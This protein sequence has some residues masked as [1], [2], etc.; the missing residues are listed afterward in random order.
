MPLVSVLII[1]DHPV[2][3]NNLFCSNNT[4]YDVNHDDSADS[5]ALEGQEYYIDV[6]P[7]T[8]LVSQG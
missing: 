6:D 5:N 1:L 7:N 3:Q 4:I 2:H 8:R